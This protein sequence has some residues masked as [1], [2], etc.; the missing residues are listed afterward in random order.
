MVLALNQVTLYNL[1][2]P[3]LFNLG[4]HTLE[5]LENQGL[6]LMDN[7]TGKEVVQ[8]DEEA[9]YLL[10]IALTSLCQQQQ[11]SC[12]VIPCLL[13]FIQRSKQG[14][15]R[16]QDTMLLTK[17]IRLDVSKQD[18]ATLEFM[19][20]KCRGLYNWWVMVRTVLPK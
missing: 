14:R 16:K 3:R 15:E 10:M 11:E 4:T 19:Q 2:S 18:A 8:L 9:A 5:V 17:K 12:A 7:T 1:S 20:S 6:L 13:P